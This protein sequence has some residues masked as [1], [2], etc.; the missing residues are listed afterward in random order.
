MYVSLDD[1]ATNLNQLVTDIR[2][3]PKKYLSVSVF[4]RGREAGVTQYT[5][6]SRCSQRTYCTIS[7][8]CSR[9]TSGRGGMSPN[10]Q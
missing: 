5:P 4:E 10:L 6:A 7:S 9:E 3:E 8:T 2:R 1:A